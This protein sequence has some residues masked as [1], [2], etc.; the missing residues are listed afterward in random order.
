MFL[1]VCVVMCTRSTRPVVFG[2]SPQSVPWKKEVDDDAR[3]GDGLLVARKKKRTSCSSQEKERV[4]VE[5]DE[6]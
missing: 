2:W 3:S 5:D 1:D 4:V 6:D